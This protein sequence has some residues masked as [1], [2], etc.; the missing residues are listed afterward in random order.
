MSVIIAIM[1]GKPR[2]GKTTIQDKCAS[3]YDG[4]LTG[5]KI[6]SSV[7]VIYE[8]YKRLGWNGVKDD[9]FRSDMHDLK[10]IYIGNCD[11][12]T[13]DIVKMAI[14]CMNDDEYE[15]TIIFY[16]CR[17]KS[18]IDKTKQYIKPLGIIG[19][20]CKTVLVKRC[21]DVDDLMHGN[22]SDDGV[23]MDDDAYDITIY[24]TDNSSEL[25]ISNADSLVKQL[26]EVNKNV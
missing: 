13:R 14:N 26:L 22:E 9:K 10:Q 8:V 11:G 3:M 2:S 1:N 15:D 24:N 16:D 17:E 12:P 18:E 6:A 4:T 7:G 19:I 23:V 21:N 5:I 20:Y 25:L